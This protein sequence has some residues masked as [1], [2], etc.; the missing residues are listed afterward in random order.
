MLHGIA[1]ITLGFFGI[2]VFGSLGIIVGR[3]FYKNVKNEEKKEK[4]QV[5]QRI[6][7]RTP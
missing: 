3:I 6:M 2:V 1:F 7:K 5:I 4:G